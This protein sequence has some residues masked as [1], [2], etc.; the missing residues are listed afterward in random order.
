MLNNRDNNVILGLL[1]TR[2]I[3][4]V[5]HMMRINWAHICLHFSSVAQL[6]SVCSQTMV[7]LAILP[8]AI[9]SFRGG[10]RSQG[11]GMH[12]HPTPFEIRKVQSQYSRLCWGEIPAEEAHSLRAAGWQESH[13][14]ISY[15][16][17]PVLSIRLYV[18][19]SPPDAC[20]AH[21]LPHWGEAASILFPPHAA[22]REGPF[23]RKSIGN[24]S[25][26]ENW[27]RWTVQRI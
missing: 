4:G 27:K 20:S 9:S 19:T 11:V 7:V 21:S 25:E 15:H 23:S 24:S 5:L 22:K 26:I 13:P 14:L 16:E 17:L 18:S 10:L 8:L 12:S 2:Y 1:S 3:S 6:Y